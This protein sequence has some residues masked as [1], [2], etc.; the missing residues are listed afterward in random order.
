MKTV[1]LSSPSDKAKRH[2]FEAGLI[3]AGAAGALA[4]ESQPANA[5]AADYIGDINTA[6]GSVQTVMD[7]A[8]PIAIG[9]F[10]IGIVMY[11]VKR[12]FYS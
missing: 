7:T 3:A 12:V 9:I 8:I 1:T 2:A 6:V 10:G 11:G 5:Q 4:I